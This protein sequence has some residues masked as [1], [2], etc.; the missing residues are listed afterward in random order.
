MSDS[1]I[2]DITVLILRDIRDRLDGTNERL[3]TLTGE[4][5]V[6]SERVSLIDQTVKVAVEKIGTVGRVVKN[7]HEK[8]LENLRERVTRLERKASGGGT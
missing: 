1:D 8:E 4:V 3:D 7:K 6:L 2:T 5:Q